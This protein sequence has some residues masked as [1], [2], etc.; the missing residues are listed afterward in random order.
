ML[1]FSVRSTTKGEAVEHLRRYT[2][3]DAVFYA[4]DD[5]TDE[6]AFAAL[7][8][9]DVGVKSGEGPTEAAFRVAGPVRSR[10]CSPR[11]RPSA[12][13]T[14]TSSRSAV[15][16]DLRAL[17]PPSPRG[18]LKTLVTLQVRLSDAVGSSTNRRSIT[19][20]IGHD[21]GDGQ[22]R[23]SSRS[24]V[25][26]GGRHRPFPTRRRRLESR[27]R[28]AGDRRY[29]EPRRLTAT[30][31]SGLRYG[32]GA[33]QE[34]GWSCESSRS[35]TSA[36]GERV[37]GRERPAGLEV[38][39]QSCARPPRHHREPESAVVHRAGRAAQGL[40]VSRRCRAG[41][42]REHDVSNTTETDQRK[43]H[44]EQATAVLGYGISIPMK[45]KS[46]SRPGSQGT[47]YKPSTR[48]PRPTRSPPRG[49]ALTVARRRP[50]PAPR[51]SPPR[52]GRSRTRSPG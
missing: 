30:G 12:K 5:V 17:Q 15:A 22:H 43:P 36:T 49:H 46:N 48:L 10:R 23:A 51:R 11:S 16:R 44:G 31:R 45:M 4:G 32:L 52:D 27:R 38:G 24:V 20:T 47:R 35:R 42:P 13:A 29:E 50:L 39:R 37:V 26:L 1:E 41:A 33:G 14:C 6:D 21:L 19:G 2:G 3:A 9:H 34:G 7:L 18:R 8:P 28:R 25:E 40:G